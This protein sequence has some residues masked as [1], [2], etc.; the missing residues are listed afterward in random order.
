[1]AEQSLR[2]Y[3][4]NELGVKPKTRVIN[5]PVGR[6]TVPT[7]SK[8]AVDFAKAQR[9]VKRMIDGGASEQEIDGYLAHEGTSAAQMKVYSRAKSGYTNQYGHHVQGS[10]DTPQWLRGTAGGSSY[11]LLDEV[12]GA[13]ENLRQKSENLARRVT[14]KPI[15]ISGDQAG[16]AAAAAEMDANTEGAQAHPVQNFV[17]QLAGGFINPGNAVGGKYIGGAKN[18]AQATLRS[19]VVGGVTG[20]AYG[21]GDGRTVQ[22]R[23]KNA[24][25]GGAFGATIGAAVPGGAR[26]AQKVANKVLSKPAQQGL[27]QAVQALNRAGVNY[28]DL[29]PAA[30]SE[31]MTLLAKG[32]KAEDVVIHVLAKSQPQPVN[33]SL[34]KLTADPAQQMEESL[35]FKGSRGPK[36]QAQMQQNVQDTQDALRN[37]ANALAEHIG[38][39]QAPARGSGVQAVSQ[40]LNAGYD[41]VKT[42]TSG[43]YQAAEEAGHGANLPRE[44]IPKLGQSMRESVKTFDPEVIAPVIRVMNGLDSKG[45]LTVRD[46]M[47]ARARFTSLVPE[48][49]SVGA[50]AGKAKRAI[51]DF[52]TQALADGKVSGDQKAI[53]TLRQAI[54][55]RAEQ[56]ATYESGDLVAD[57]VERDYRSGKMQLKVDPGDAATKVMG[58]TGLNF[59]DRPNLTRDTA[60]LRDVLKGGPEWHQFRAEVFNRVLESSNGEMVAGKQAFSGVKF[61]KAWAKLKANNGRTLD[62]LFTP[63]ERAKIDQFAAVANRATETVSGGANTSNTSVAMKAL[64]GKILNLIKGAPFG[65]DAANMIENMAAEKQISRSVGKVRPRLNPKTRS[66]SPYSVDA[67]PTAA[68]VNALG[69]QPKR[70][71]GPPEP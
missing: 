61:A 44:E 24:V 47:E 65:K 21:A 51:D 46:Y 33:M 3:V 53:D 12:M 25:I 29:E 58:P 68:V 38:G 50:A 16:E 57:L 42:K 35:A 64:S 26:V 59:F 63:A 23:Q 18:L 69:Y 56:G 45:T 11:Q 34:G 66:P 55:S 19:A 52:F 39:G 48:G 62:V 41:A 13:Q 20:A 31:I 7:E 28:T 5:T 14:G 71:T 49:K 9:N 54:G 40:K 43:L 32:H 2:T 60:R 30:Q 70:R 22:E 27:N 15:L 1:M 36:A 6:A 10:N 67:Y 8:P 17:G 4:G 37:N